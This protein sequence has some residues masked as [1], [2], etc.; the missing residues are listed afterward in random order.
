[1][2]EGQTHHRR[3]PG[4]HIR[5]SP[6]NKVTKGV[7]LPSL[8]RSPRWKSTTTHH[9]RGFWKLLSISGLSIGLTRRAL[10]EL[11]RFNIKEAARD[12]ESRVS[13]QEHLPSD[14]KRFSRHADYPELRGVSPAR[15][16]SMQILKTRQY[17]EPASIEMASSRSQISSIS[18]K[19]QRKSKGTFKA[20]TVRP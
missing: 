14:I 10:Q 7:H 8:P 18:N 11:D 2:V 3:N 6:P 4:S 12:I 1:M 19:Q 5:V 13:A 20:G 17:P 16:P 15:L 9:A